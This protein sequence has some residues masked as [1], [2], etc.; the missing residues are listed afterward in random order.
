[1]DERRNNLL[2]EI[3]ETYIK[4]VKPVGS[5]ALCDKFNCSSATIRNEMV[6][7]E[8]LGY[9]EKNHISSGRIPSEAG[10]RYYVE[11]LMEPEELT[12]SDMLKLQKIFTNSELEL[13]D[14]ILKCME[15]ISDITNYTSVVLGN[16]SSDNNLLQVN[17]IAI[18]DHEV[19]AVVCTDKGNVENKSFTLSNNINVNEVI[20]TSELI[21]KMLVGTPINEVSSRLELDI[22]PI[23]K[24]QISQYEAVYNIFYD[25]FNNFVSNNSNIHVAGKTKIFEQPE[26]NSID[27]LKRLSNK[28]ED[29]SLISKVDAKDEDMNDIKIYIGEENEFDPNVT[30]IRKKYHIDG[31]DGTVAIIGPKRMDYQR[32]VGMLE[33]VDKNLDSRK[34]KDGKKE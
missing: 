24:K 1:M 14:A 20:K 32:I 27:E 6:V 10:Y 18:N 4:T 3:V 12:G 7:L 16:N 8:N 13:S 5:K 11:N 26:Y 23:I 19:V 9:L 15:I 22:K 28:F 25:A 29:M 2:K 34:E 33:Y 30:I 21:N 31:K 17:I